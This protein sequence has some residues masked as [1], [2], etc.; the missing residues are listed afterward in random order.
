MGTEDKH[1]E[2]QLDSARMMKAEKTIYI[3]AGLI[4]L[5]CIFTDAIGYENIRQYLLGIEHWD[6]AAVAFIRAVV[7][8]DMD[9]ILTAFYSIWVVTITVTIFVTQISETYQQYGINLKVIIREL[10]GEKGVKRN[11]AIYLVLFPTVFF[12]SN[13]GKKM[14]CMW[15]LG[16]AFSGLVILLWFVQKYSKEWEIRLLVEW[17]TLRQ[18]QDSHQKGKT[19]VDAHNEQT[20]SI[21]QWI[22]SFLVT[23]MLEHVDYTKSD[24]ASLIIRQLSKILADDQIQL[25]ATQR[26]TGGM[27]LL[28]W[29]KRIAVKSGFHTEYEKE[30][31]LN[32]FKELWELITSAVKDPELR[33]LYSVH[34]IL[35][36]IDARDADGNEMLVRLRNL[37]GEYGEWSLPYLLLYTEYRYWFVDG[38][39]H[40]W[41]AIDDYNLQL[42]LERIRKGKFIWNEETAWKYWLDWCQYNGSRGDIGIKQFSK[43]SDG[44]EALQ[45]G[46]NGR[47]CTPVILKL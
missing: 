43:F 36:F 18:L 45:K 26:T 7:P 23:D 40:D 16:A 41:I 9:H 46:T 37:L 30:R 33:L 47:V 11:I 10:L 38:T 21:R 19:G 6:T 17:C 34:L 15:C 24:E 27:L 31:T 14:I 29:A 8:D 4:L 3:W 5:G 13:A 42:D 20:G 44:M 32:L 35:P 2:N 39:V 22:D 28:T 1:C 12:G 25:Q